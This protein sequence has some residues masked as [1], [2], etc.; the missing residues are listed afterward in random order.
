MRLVFWTFQNW[1]N[2]KADELIYTLT[3]NLTGT[4]IAMVKDGIIYCVPPGVLAGIMML[5]LYFYA[6]RKGKQF[7]KAI[8]FGGSVASIFIIIGGATFF[9]YKIDFL[10]YIKNQN[11]YS[12]F[13]DENYVAPDSVQITFPERKRNLVYLYIESMEVSFSDTIHGGGKNKNLIPEL[14]ELALEAET[15][16]NDSGFLNGGYSLYGSTYTMGGMFAQTTGLPLTTSHT[17]IQLSESFMP[18]IIALGDIL[19][20]AGYHNVLCIGT[21]AAF[22]DRDK[23]FRE[24]GN[25]T[26]YDY[27]Y[28][29]AKEEIPSDYTRD[30]WGYDDYILYENAKQHLLDLAKDD[31]P[32][33]FTMLTVDTHAEDG[34]L[35]SLCSDIYD[36]KYSNVIACSSMQAAEFVRWIQ[37]QDFYENTTIILAGDHCSM[38]SNIADDM[39]KDYDRRIYTAFINSS[40]NLP[41]PVNKFRQYASMDFFPSTLAALGAQIEG[42]QLGLGTNLFSEKETLIEHYGIEAMNKNLAQKSVLLEQALGDKRKMRPLNLSYN[43]STGIFHIAVE[44]EIEYAGEYSGLKCI[45]NQEESGVNYSLDLTKN[46]NGYMADISLEK[47]YYKPGKYN[48]DV[49]LILPDKL[50]KWYSSGSINI[51][52]IISPAE[53]LLSKDGD[54]LGIVYNQN[55][56]NYPNIYF[57]V[58]SEENGQDDLVWCT[59]EKKN[60]SWVKL[61]DLSTHTKDGNLLVHIYGGKDSP[62]ECLYMGILPLSRFEQ[63]DDKALRSIF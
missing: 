26:I 18:G 25:Y 29:V 5:I 37:K 24:H 27:N 30:F 48:C 45:I 39:P 38:D 13:I 42:E 46:E 33:N 44:G 28:S 61:I 40:P 12:A 2:L 6:E 34:C 11:Q 4:N 62:K 31:K 14:T 1:G 15:F 59:A 50:T 20:D 43:D 47:G 54:T 52:K 49:Y 21:D 60:E 22:A 56:T 8:I 53:F 3:A 19:E 58:W 17:Q 36:D 9:S 41:S 57:A 16:S 23:Y 51:E 35:C 10:N 55:K 32:F 7:K 63:C